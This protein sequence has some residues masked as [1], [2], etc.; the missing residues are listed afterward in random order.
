[1]APGFLKSDGYSEA[2]VSNKR[3]QRTNFN[4]RRVETVIRN[5]D[6]RTRGND[7]R[8]IRILFLDV[9]LGEGAGDRGRIVAARIGGP[10]DLGKYGIQRIRRRK[11]RFI[12]CCEGNGRR[13]WG[14]RL[15]GEGERGQ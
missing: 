13:R 14:T 9:G 10:L 12:T 8:M 5:T 7:N 1:M 15:L 2:D 11:H 4:E 6:V 3:D